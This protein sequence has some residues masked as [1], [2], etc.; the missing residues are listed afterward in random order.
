MRTVRYLAVVIAATAT[1]A[2]CGAQQAGPGGGATGATGAATPS[3]AASAGSPAATSAVPPPAAGCGGVT[4]TAPPEHT[5][6][7][8]TSSNGGSFCVRP[9]T[10][11]LVYLK[12]TPAARWTALTSSSAALAPKANGHLMLALG[13]TGGSFV[14]AT[15]GIAVITSQR[16][17]CGPS[18]PPTAPTTS[19]KLLCGTVQVFK[20][21]VRVAG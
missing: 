17:L 21:T 11:V 14:A 3:A 19:H 13:V 20:V 5:L 6:T 10:A 9:G 1:V 7:L 16:S 18:V 8:T 4:P 12:G 2:A 15:R